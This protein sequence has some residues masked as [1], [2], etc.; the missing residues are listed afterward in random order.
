MIK[1][2][3]S[4]KTEEE[5]KV[6]RLG[7]KKLTDIIDFLGSLVKPGVSA[8]EFEATAEKLIRE[9]KGRCN[10]KGEDGFPS[11][12]CFSVNEEIVHGVPQNKIL[13]VGD[14]VS[15]DLGIFFPL[16]VFLKDI[17]L[18][19]YP[20]LKEGFHTDMARTYFVG[21]TDPEIQRLVRV[22][23]KAL[24]RGIKKCKPGVTFGDIG[25][26]I[27]R[28]IESQGFEIV[29][30]LCG[31]GIGKELHEK[32]DI[33]NYGQRHTGE[34]LKPGMVFCLEP[35]LTLGSGKIKKRGMTYVSA[36]GS[37]AAHFEDMVAI[38][39]TGAIVLTDR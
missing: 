9:A 21:E 33:P 26:T 17:D 15:L 30:E 14:V 6:M 1:N 18:K 27:Q 37:P 25:E 35:M 19:K 11:C 16:N 38:T 8:E 12:L 28:Y 10:F 7:G 24:K 2:T 23:K 5:I 4:I 22:T 3:I 13:Q 39:K 29:Y 32:P 36:D 20:N 31:H 34:K